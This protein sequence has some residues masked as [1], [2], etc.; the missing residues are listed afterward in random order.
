MNSCALRVNSIA[1]HIHSF[2]ASL[3]AYELDL[4]GA[5]NRLLYNY[6]SLIIRSDGGQVA[7]L[8]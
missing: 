2:E 7:A 5:F 4:C 3:M 6:N 8:F 1:R